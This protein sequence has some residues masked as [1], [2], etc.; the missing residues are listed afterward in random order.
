M[1]IELFSYFYLI[2][3]FDYFGLTQQTLDMIDAD[4]DAIGELDD[5]A[6]LI[7]KVLPIIALIN[8]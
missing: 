2:T 3:L 1:K 6:I 7:G 5:I 8:L 4:D